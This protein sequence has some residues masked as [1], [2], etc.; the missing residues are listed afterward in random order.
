MFALD[1]LLTTAIFDPRMAMTISHIQTCLSSCFSVDKM[2]GV[3]IEDV[4]NRHLQRVLDQT[5]WCVQWADHFHWCRL[6]IPC[7]DR[8]RLGNCILL[9]S[10]SCPESSLASLFLVGTMESLA[11]SPV[12]ACE[13][14][15]VE[16]VICYCTL[17]LWSKIQPLLA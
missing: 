6:R 15:R 4:C 3:S 2:L 14:R 12:C 11:F 17:T 8:Q 13:R 7:G 1:V 16:V 10:R 5:R 9:G